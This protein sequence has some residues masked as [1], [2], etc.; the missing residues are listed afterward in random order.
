MNLLSLM[1]SRQLTS[2]HSRLFAYQL[3]AALK[4]AHGLGIGHF[5]L[6]P[7]NV[8]V[9]YRNLTLKVADFG[10]SRLTEGS[11]VASED[12]LRMV[13]CVLTFVA[14][15]WF[16]S[17]PPELFVICILFF[18]RMYVVHVGLFVKHA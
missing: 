1:S 14:G 10:I 12:R 6:K 18:L 15:D 16:Y 13:S 17:T 4:H 11:V 3:F 9:C 2:S 8:L 5:G 7:S